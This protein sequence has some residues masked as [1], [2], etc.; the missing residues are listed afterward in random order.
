LK[1]FIRNNRITLLGLLAGSV[2]GIGY[3]L[4]LPVLKKHRVVYEYK[5][6]DSLSLSPCL[7][8]DTLFTTTTG[9]VRNYY[10]SH[11]DT[12]IDKDIKRS[13]LIFFHQKQFTSELV[14]STILSPLSENRTNVLTVKIDGEKR[15]STALMTFPLLGLLLG[16]LLGFGIA[17]L[18]PTK[19][20]SKTPI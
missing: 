14:Q 18:K 2:I 1:E 4:T 7:Q 8:S 16:Y 11:A 17:K 20:D 15:N 10:H 9:E 5:Q 6:Q 19:Q 12:L 13:E 3:H